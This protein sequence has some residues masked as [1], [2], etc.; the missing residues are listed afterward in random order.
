ML[1]P[2][3]HELAALQAAGQAGGAYVEALAKT[4]LAAWT[5]EEW[6]QLVEIIV[7]HFQDTL[8]TAYADD[9]PF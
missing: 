4:D 3:T 1:D 8:R 6:S 7:T 9:P 2:N 5:A